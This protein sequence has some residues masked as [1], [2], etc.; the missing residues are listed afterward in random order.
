MVVDFAEPTI[1]FR[2]SDQGRLFIIVESDDL[3]LEQA[4]DVAWYPL[5]RHMDWRPLLPVG[6]K[7]YDA[8]FM[9]NVAQAQKRGVVLPPNSETQDEADAR[10]LFERA[11]MDEEADV[12]YQAP[13]GPAEMPYRPCSVNDIAPG[14]VPLRMAGRPPKCFFAMVKAFMGVIVSGRAPTPEN[15]R[16][17]L[18]ENPAFARACAF[19][20]PQ[21]G[22]HRQS[23][24]PSLRKL[25]QFDQIMEQN[26]LWGD[27]K[28][29]AVKE[30]LKN[31]V[32]KPEA[33]A[34]HDTTHHLAYSQRRVVTATEPNE[35]PA[36]A[37][38]MAATAEAGETASNADEPAS[39][40]AEEATVYTKSQSRT[41]KNCR[42]ADRENC[43]HPWVNADDGA[44][45][46]VKHGGKMY[47]AHKSSTISFADQ[48]VLLDA[49]AVS[50]AA[51]HDSRTVPD[52]LAR[53]F[54]L[55]PELDGTITR[56][57]DD[58]AADEQ[59]LKD[60][61]W[62]EWGI[63]LMT[64]INPRG[65]KA[66]VDDLPKGIERISPR[67]V[68][69]C[70]AGFPMD[71]VGC[72][73]ADSRFL[74]RAPNDEN[75]TPVCQGCAIREQCYRGDS[76]ARQITVPFERLPWIDPDNPQL[77]KRFE[78]AMA[79]RSVIERMHKLMKFDYGDPQLTKRGN[80]SFQGILDKTVMAMHLMLA[81]K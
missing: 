15:V 40:Q 5:L 27:G 60:L 72:R 51:V 37:D 33:T 68:P 70:L 81:L 44:G 34:V 13:T 28:V 65:R 67:G 41:T 73:H 29:T 47:W 3:Y 49:V 17:M 45:T 59:S 16:Q 57:L 10:L 71:F 26:G 43:G 18:V 76:G 14:V 25:E 4:E 32:V 7:Y 61:V 54:D 24:V 35:T 48:E 46:V 64:P 36:N 56:L 20:L 75:G 19:T 11:T 62:N 63:E 53:L 42:C 39:P 52:H 66:I 50:D 1:Q 21:P 30:N 74:F 79:R 31:G 12:L 69:T 23:D 80:A 55:H 77:S 22:R 58:R 6:A 2:D 9:F 78:K 8:L 38:A